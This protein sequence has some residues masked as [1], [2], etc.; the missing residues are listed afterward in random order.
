MHDVFLFKFYYLCKHFARILNSRGIKFM[1][2]S[3]NKVLANNSEFT[4]FQ[5]VHFHLTFSILNAWAPIICKPQP[6]LMDQDKRLPAQFS[7][8][9][10]FLPQHHLCRAVTLRNCWALDSLPQ[11]ASLHIYISCSNW[12]VYTFT[13][14]AQIGQFTHLHFLLK[15]ASLHIYIPCS[16]WPVYTFT[17]WDLSRALSAVAGH[18]RELCLRVPGIPWPC[19]PC[20][21]TYRD[22]RGIAGLM[23]GAMTFWIHPQYWV[24]AGL[25]YYVNIPRGIYFYKEQGYDSQQVP[26][27]SRAVMDE[28]SLSP[29]FPVVGRGGGQ[30]LQ[31][32]GALGLSF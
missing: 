4:V 13:F 6:L 15:L 23:C 3:E 32:T 11:L 31:M 25:W 21:L 19:N 8:R 27:F 14:P 7:S 2:I 30:W 12:P 5:K 20:P 18:V 9:A 29:L 28:K 17:C 1:N 22:G 16:D 24:S 10:R 26:A